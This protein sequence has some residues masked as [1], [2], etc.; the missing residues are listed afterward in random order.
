MQQKS[1]KVIVCK[2][3]LAKANQ[4]HIFVIFEELSKI[5]PTI[6]FCLLISN[7]VTNLPTNAEDKKHRFNPWVGKRPWQPTP[8]LVPGESHGQRSL[9]G[10]SPSSPKETDM[11]E[12]T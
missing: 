6:Y 7:T 3:F 5:V 2:L 11:A 1:I 10:Y 12:E 8:V 4:R 9:V